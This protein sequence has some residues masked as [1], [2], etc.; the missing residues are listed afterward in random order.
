MYSNQIHGALR[1]I[2]DAIDVLFGI[3]LGQL[4]ADD[5][6]RL[7]GRCESLA[8]RHSVVRGDI[9]HE[10][11][12]R[13][14][15]ELGGA[16][17]KVLADWLRI[18]PA[19]ARRRAS[20]V[21]PLAAR[22]ALSGESL[23]PRQPK[24][25][26][27]WRA[28]ELD[29][30]HVRVIQRFLAELPV[31]VTVAAREWA[32]SV[33]AEQAKQ[34]RPDQLSKLAE[35]LA[36]ILNPD[37]KFTEE[38]RAARRGFSF[39]PQHANGMSRGILWATPALRA[40]IEAWFAK[41]A[42]PG[43]CNPADQS[44]LVDGEPTQAQADA[45]VRSHPQRQHD[46]LSALLRGRLGDPQ[47]GLH[48]GLPVTVIV[49]ASLQDLEAKTGFATTAGGTVLPI[50]DLIRMAGH[51]Y[52][53]LSLFDAATGRSLWLGR[54]KR[55]ASADQRIVLHERDRGCTFP[56][57]T[58]SG[59]DCEVHHAAKDWADGG[60]TDVDDLSFACGPHNRLVKR[61]GWQTRKL[62]D[63][64]TEW[65]PPPQLPLI[66]GINTYHHPDRLL[67]QSG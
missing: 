59:Y 51:A 47:L 15:S 67:D 22:T 45:D 18:T 9:A 44:P 50:S 11:Q 52:H 66:G 37:G 35:K 13:D 7:A 41:F 3:D 10:L 2:D 4:S 1:S 54:T 48:K 6:V 43:M 33:L 63:G 21:E 5:L 12:R 29:V 64:T 17:H 16:P 53:Y 34:L 8:R 61:G 32:E 49:S 23:P 38:D 58:V 40:E 24:T 56:G 46:A 31:D 42:A 39:G 62:R 26:Q 65:L 27:A 36:M 60:A 19:E 25:A 14:V 55:I 57:C 30:E 20:L 28:G